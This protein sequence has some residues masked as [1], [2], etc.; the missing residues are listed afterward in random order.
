MLLVHH[1]QMHKRTMKPHE[2]IAVLL[3]KRGLNP[4][5][6]AQ[7]MGRQSL[8]TML[9]RYLQGGVRPRI[10]SAQL[11]A[12]FFQ[13]PLEAIWSETVATQT[14]VQMGLIPGSKAAQLTDEPE[15]ITPQATV[16]RLGQLLAGASP[17]TRRAVVELIR[18]LADKPNDSHLVGAQVAALLGVSGKR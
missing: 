1:P 15:P 17:P 5:S 8:Q 4:N 9:F 2:L 11:M 3:E 13:V 14:A 10:E 6:A 16:Q 7:E 12:T 18:H